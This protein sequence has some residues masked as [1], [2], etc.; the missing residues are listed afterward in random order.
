MVEMLLEFLQPFVTNYLR[1]FIELKTIT[2]FVIDY[3]I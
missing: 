1:Y 2:L 3:L